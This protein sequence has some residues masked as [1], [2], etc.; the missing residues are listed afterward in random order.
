MIKVGLLSGGDFGTLGNDGPEHGAV[1][2]QFGAAKQ[3]L[4]S[5][6]MR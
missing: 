5:G 2:Q 4:F 1:K 3:Q 6:G